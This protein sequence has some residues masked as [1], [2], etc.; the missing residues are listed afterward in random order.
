VWTQI[1]WHYCYGSNY[2]M[3][4]TKYLQMGTQLS[5]TSISIL[6]SP[7]EGVHRTL[8]WIWLQSLKHKEQVD[9]EWVECYNLKESRYLL[10]WFGISLLVK[11]ASDCVV[12]MFGFFIKIECW[13]LQQCCIPVKKLVAIL[14]TAKE[15]REDTV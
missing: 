10:K 8:S 14:T 13:G 3:T 5:S 11:I 9:I 7:H 4:M 12:C 1:L 6:T 15:E 2:L